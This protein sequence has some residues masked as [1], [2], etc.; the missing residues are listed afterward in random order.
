MKY[1]KKIFEAK[2]YTAEERELQDFCDMYLAYLVDDGFKVLVD[3]IS[4][5]KNT[6]SITIIPETEKG[7]EKFKTTDWSN[8]KDKLIPFF[9]MLVKNYNIGVDPNQG[10]VFHPSWL[11]STVS[12]DC[13]VSGNEIVHSIEI[14]KLIEDQSEYPLKAIYLIELVVHKQK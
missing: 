1:L 5:F 12:F 2:Y 6:L 9:V 11:E 10:S 4:G 14:K 8:I 7:A 13:S 3:K